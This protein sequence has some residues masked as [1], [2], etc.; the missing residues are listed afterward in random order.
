MLRL[1]ATASLIATTSIV[2][3]GL[4]RADPYLVYTHH[5]TRVDVHDLDLTRDA[6]LRILKVRIGRAADQVCGDRPDRG[7][8]YNQT[9]LKLLLPAY[10]RCRTAAI[11][12]A[13]AAVKVPAQM[14]AG[15][16]TDEDGR[17]K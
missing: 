1:I 8:R 12:R 2:W 16:D 9:E 7:N 10:D 6:D 3:A 17:P 4:A 13:A 15:N 11:Q 5:A 14:L